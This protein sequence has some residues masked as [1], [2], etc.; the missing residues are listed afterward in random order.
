QPWQDNQGHAGF[1]WATLA[2]LAQRT[3]RLRMGTAVTCPSFRY[4]P[5]VVA[6]AFATLSQ[7]APGRVY[8]GVGSGEALNEQAAAGGWGEY[9]ER[10]ERLVEAVTI[11]R[12]LWSGQKVEHRGR[13]FQVQGRLYDPPARPIPL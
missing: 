9:E 1:A 3:S 5:A 11:I 2:A 8:L 7:L 12:R 10:A 6:Q 13:H 4:Q